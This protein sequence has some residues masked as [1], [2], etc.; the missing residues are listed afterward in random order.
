VIFIRLVS[1][2]DSFI[3]NNPINKLQV[4]EGMNELQKTTQDMSATVK[5]LGQGQECQAIILF[6]K[7]TLLP[8]EKK[9]Q[10]NGC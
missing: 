9:V 8:N 6:N 1:F 4:K 5:K 7:A 10:G 3:T 2:A